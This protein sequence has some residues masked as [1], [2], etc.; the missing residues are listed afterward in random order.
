MS[1]GW[2][3]SSEAI[4]TKYSAFYREGA[5]VS[6]EG[7]AAVDTA[8]ESTDG[9]SLEALGKYLPFLDADAIDIMKSLPDGAT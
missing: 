6:P 9:D 8:K 3:A 7:A 1:N 2:K 5:L 4:E